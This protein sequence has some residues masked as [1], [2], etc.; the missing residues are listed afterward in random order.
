MDML[1]IFY[2]IS[3]GGL[4]YIFVVV[5]FQKKDEIPSEPDF[6]TFIFSMEWH[7]GNRSIDV[8]AD[9]Q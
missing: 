8:E 2:T 4:Q 3:P 6:C 5:H 9:E 1:H 7:Y